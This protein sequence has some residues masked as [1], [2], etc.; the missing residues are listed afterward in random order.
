M[1]ALSTE[2]EEKAK[3]KKG[4]EKYQPEAVERSSKQNIKTERDM[5]QYKKFYIILREEQL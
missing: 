5:Y 2:R 3:R 4:G 1:D